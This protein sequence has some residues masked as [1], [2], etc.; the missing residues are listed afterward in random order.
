MDASETA[1]QLRSEC[2]R[3]AGELDNEIST[4]AL[5]DT[6]GFSSSPMQR[7]SFLLLVWIHFFLQSF[8]V[9]LN[10]LRNHLCL[11][12]LPSFCNQELVI[13]GHCSSS[14]AATSNA[15]NEAWPLQERPQD[16]L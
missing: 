10:L 1:A 6:D 11:E 4:R 8:S 13:D 14:E 15:L 5:E 9:L 3:R 2:L 7:G 16:K 12:D